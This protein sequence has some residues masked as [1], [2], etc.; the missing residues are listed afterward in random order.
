MNKKNAYVR[1]FCCQDV[2]D[3]SDQPIIFWICKAKP[4][5]FETLPFN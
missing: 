5:C 2:Q 3:D 1:C 4:D